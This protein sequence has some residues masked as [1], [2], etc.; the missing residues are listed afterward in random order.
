MEELKVAGAAIVA[1]GAAFIA[2]VKTQGKV[3]SKRAI[4]LYVAVAGI[5]G[6]AVIAIVN[7]AK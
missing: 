2:V 3:L 6:A 1:A 4:A 5:A 7:A